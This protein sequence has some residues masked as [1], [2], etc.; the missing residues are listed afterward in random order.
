MRRTAAVL[1]LL[2]LVLAMGCSRYLQVTVYSDPYGASL[3]SGRT[4]YGQCPSTVNWKLTGEAMSQP[5]LT[6]SG[7]TAC[8]PSGATK[9]SGPVLLNLRPLRPKNHVLY[10]IRAFLL[11]AQTDAFSYTLTRDYK[12]DSDAEALRYDQE[13]GE[14]LRAQRIRQAQV[15]LLTFM[16]MQQALDPSRQTRASSPLDGMAEAL[17]QR[18]AQ[19]LLRRNCMVS[20]ETQ[21]GWSSE[22]LAEVEFA[23]GIQLSQQ[24]PGRSYNGVSAYA[25]LWFGPGQVA[26]LESDCTFLDVSTTFG[27]AQFKSLYFLND[28]LS[29]TQIN[30]NGARKYRIRAKDSV[31]FIDPRSR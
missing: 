13:M 29:F 26:I 15:A 3:N 24:V 9:S 14:R 8:W 1:S 5:T 4:S 18:A 19:G 10:S 25:L 20:Y 22:V 30:G 2:A 17:Q 6:I 23:T 11:G 21:S 31:F 28:S 7:M 12:G 27:E 16:A